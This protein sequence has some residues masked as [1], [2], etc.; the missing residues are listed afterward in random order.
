VKCVKFVV[1]L[2][3]KAVEQKVI[4]RRGKLAAQEQILLKLILDTWSICH[5]TRQGL[6]N[7]EVTLRGSA[8][9]CLAGHIF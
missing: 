3:I 6:S 5:N 8:R 1:Y 2:A 9:Q 4:K 7:F